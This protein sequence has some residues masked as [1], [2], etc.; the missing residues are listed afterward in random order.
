MNMPF[1]ESIETRLMKNRIKCPEYVLQDWV[2]TVFYTED[3]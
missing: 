2:K 1:G 3:D